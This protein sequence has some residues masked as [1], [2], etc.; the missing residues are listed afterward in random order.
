MTNEATRRFFNCFIDLSKRPEPR[1]LLH[2]MFDPAGM[3][4]FITDWAE[5]AKS[6]LAKSSGTVGRVMDPQTKEL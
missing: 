3:R 1:N 5:T 6:L 4:P 2:L